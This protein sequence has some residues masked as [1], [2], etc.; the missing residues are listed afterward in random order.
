[1]RWIAVMSL[2][3][4][5]AIAIAIAACGDR[6]PDR[7]QQSKSNEETGD[8][9]DDAAQPAQQPDDPWARPPPP[10]PG[11]PGER[12][13]CERVDFARSVPIAEASGAAYVPAAGDRA[14]FVLVVSDSGN[15]GDYV[16]IDAE[17]GAVLRRGHLPLDKGASD[18]LEGLAVLQ[19]TYYTITSSGWVRHH[20]RDAETGTYTLTERAYAI[21]APPVVC[22]DPRQVNC[23]RNYEGL[24]LFDGP[25]TGGQCAGF[26]VSKTDGALYCLAIG[27]GTLRATDAKPIA[28]AGGEELSGCAFS[29]GGSAW[30]GANLFGGNEVY[31]VR[32]W[33]TPPTATIDKVG[34]DGPGFSEAIAIGPNGVMYRFSDD[35]RA[36]SLAEKYL[37]E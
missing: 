13:L 4:S 26:A 10:Q 11:E 2:A 25:V 30:V 20:T 7:T 32:D 15:V 22:T 19:G 37:C 29:P 1:M 12:T 17:S 23:G 27:D 34:A 8:K 36:P 28:I 9:A 5:L 6:N 21:G 14:A 33:G 31:R 3:G 16:E 18:D 24:C 35:G